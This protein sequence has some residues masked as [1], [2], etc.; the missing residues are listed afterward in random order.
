MFKK[1]E[2]NN[3]VNVSVFGYVDSPNKIGYT[4]IPLYV[5]EGKYD[6]TNRLFFQKDGSKSHY[7]VANS[8]S[9]LVGS[10][11][12]KRAKKFVCDRCLCLFWRQDSLDKHSKY[13][14][15]HDAV[16]TLMPVPGVNDILRFKNIHHQ[17]PVPIMFTADFESFTKPI[18]ITHGETKLYQRHEPPAFSLYTI[19][20][21]EGFS[22]G[23]ITHVCEDE[24]DNV[25]RNHSSKRPRTALKKF[26]KSLRFLLK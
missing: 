16:K 17:L 22:P 24:N 21:V 11:S 5:S 7:G 6:K 12:K 4:I 13:C 1:S 19:S 2:K 25:A 20:R 3:N 10:H 26:T 18:D 8:I 14:S 9:R 23:I 15:E